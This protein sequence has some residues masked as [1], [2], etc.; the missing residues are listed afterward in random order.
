MSAVWW[1]IS[2]KIKCLCH[3]KLPAV[4]MKFIISPILCCFRA[5]LMV[6]STLIWGSQL[7]SLSCTL[8]AK[9]VQ[10]Q[11]AVF[12]GEKRK[13]GSPK[14]KKKL[15]FRLWDLWRENGGYS[16][17]WNQKKQSRKAGRIQNQE[18][19]KL[20]TYYQLLYC[21]PVVPPCAQQAPASWS[22][23]YCA[24]FYSLIY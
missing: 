2:V 20:V 7:L 11:R 8:A 21:W 14:K 24:R 5:E 9:Y 4:P 18:L 3:F 10:P 12:S 13:R 19:I 6:A 1:R 16:E 22:K 23:Q 17:E 15:L